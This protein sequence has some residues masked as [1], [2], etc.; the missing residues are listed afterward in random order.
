MHNTFTSKEDIEWARNYSDDIYWC[1]CPGAN[2]YI[3]GE[4]PNFQLFIDE[5]CTIGTDS[6]ASNRELSIIEELKLISK[7]NSDI[8]LEILIKWAT[9]NGAIF[10]NF[11]ELGSIETG[12]T[13]GLNLIENLD[14]E[15]LRL[16]TNSTVKK[17]I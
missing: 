8:S 9:F 11:D 5:K 7:Q 6:L 10:L 12:K 16:R 4:L 15:K 13:P 1:F 17:I 3:E 2:L 14:L